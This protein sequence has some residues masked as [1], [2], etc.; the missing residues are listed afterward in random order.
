[1]STSNGSESSEIVI[2]RMT[3]RRN[4]KVIR[5]PDGRPFK[6]VLRKKPK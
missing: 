4:G 2:F 5:R 3:I 6:I 1:M